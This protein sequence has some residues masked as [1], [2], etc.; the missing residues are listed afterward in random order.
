MYD[1]NLTSAWATSFLSLVNLFH[2]NQSFTHTKVSRVLK[3]KRQ[4]NQ[5]LQVHTQQINKEKFYF[6]LLKLPRILRR[7]SQNSKTFN[8]HT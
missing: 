4:L 2:I 5:I 6:R 3:E 7:P 1:T 8:L